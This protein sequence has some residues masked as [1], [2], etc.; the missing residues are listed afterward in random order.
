MIFVLI[1]I[2]FMYLGRKIG[3]AISKKILYPV[4]EPWG[5]ILSIVWGGV[6]ALCVRLLIDW[7]HPSIVVK[8]I[9]GF[10]LGAYV[11]VP[12]YGLFMEST[13]PPEAMA[14]HRLLSTLPFLSYIICSIYFSWLLWQSAP[15]AHA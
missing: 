12:N 1:A 7:Q 8:I 6:V 2:T 9:F 5:G 3:W 13:I 15:A 11:S 14:K 10:M 4:Q